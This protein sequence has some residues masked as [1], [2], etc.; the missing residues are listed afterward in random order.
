MATAA[1]TAVST[2]ER[3]VSCLPL[4][5]RGNVNFDGRIGVVGDR[6]ECC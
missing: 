2:F 5:R 6:I 4:F 1:I 3:V